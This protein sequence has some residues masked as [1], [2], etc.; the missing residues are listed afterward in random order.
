M[1]GSFKGL[2]PLHPTAS[3]RPLH[4]LGTASAPPPHRLRITSVSPLHMCTAFA[5]LPPSLHRLAP[6]STPRTS[7]TSV[8]THRSC[9]QWSRSIR[10]AVRPVAMA[11]ASPPHPSPPHPSPPHPISSH[12]ITPRHAAARHSPPTSSRHTTPPPGMLVSM[13]LKYTS[14]TLKNF[15]QPHAPKAAAPKAAAS[16]TAAP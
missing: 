15:A 11:G 14:A 1:A 7:A 3:L 8:G 4:R 16:K 13:L 5:L 6:P 12:P 2:S 10:R 9:G